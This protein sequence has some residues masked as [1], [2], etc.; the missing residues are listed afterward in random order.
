MLRRWLGLVASL[1]A[2]SACTLL[3]K[4]L[5]DGTDAA[6]GGDADG[7]QSADVSVDVRDADDSGRDEDVDLRDADDGSTDADDVSTD[8]CCHSED[9]TTLSVILQSF[10]APLYELFDVDPAIALPIR[11]RA[12][13]CL[14]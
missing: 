4:T 11:T 13:V 14:A 8:S 5:G 7:D 10:Q 6:P 2:L 12:P 1:I 9:V 3:H